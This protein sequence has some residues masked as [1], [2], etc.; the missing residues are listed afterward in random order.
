VRIKSSLTAILTVKTLYVH[1]GGVDYD[2]GPYNV[3]FPAG[4]THV[5]FNVS[6]FPA[7]KDKVR[8]KLAIVKRLLPD[9]IT[10]DIPGIIKVIVR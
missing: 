6:L 9:Y 1:T 10:R 7:A 8:F 4:V 2:F 5:S 3:T